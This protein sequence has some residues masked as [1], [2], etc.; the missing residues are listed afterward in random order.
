MQRPCSWEGLDAFK[1]LK[2][3]GGWD[4][5]NEEL[6][7]LRWG[8]PIWC[9]H[10]DAVSVC[11]PD[12]FLEH[13][14]QHPLLPEISHITGSL[15]SSTSHQPTC[16]T[17]HLPHL[18]WCNSILPVPQAKNLS[19]LP[20]SPL[21]PTSNLSA[22]PL[23][24]TSKLSQRPSQH[25]SHDHPVQAAMVSCLQTCLSAAILACTSPLFTY[26]DGFSSQ[27][28]PV[29]SFVAMISIQCSQHGLWAHPSHPTPSSPSLCL[30]PCSPLNTPDPLH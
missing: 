20:D 6:C 11:S 10:Y 9:Q 8:W 12:S 13:Q 24:F 23:S 22:S 7:A 17:G 16:A 19:I 18:S 15:F 25:L 14:A 21:T 27:N 5:L 26:S 4:P 3:Q 2:L 28:S 29:A 1:D 30:H